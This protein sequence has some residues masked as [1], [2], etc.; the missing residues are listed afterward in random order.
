MIFLHLNTIFNHWLE[1]NKEIISKEG[2][3]PILVD[4]IK[5]NDVKLQNE[6]LGALRNLST[7]GKI[8]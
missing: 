1:K 4:F 8:N 3:I 7:N 2:A 6:A 5:S